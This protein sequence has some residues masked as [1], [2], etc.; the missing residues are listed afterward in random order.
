VTQQIN[1]WPMYVFQAG[2]ALVSPDGGSPEIDAPPFKQALAFTSDLVL[3]HR[4]AP[5]PVGSAD[6]LRPEPLFARG[7]VAMLEVS[8]MALDHLVPLPFRWSLLP[9]PRQAQSVTLLL[10]VGIAIN[11]ATPHAAACRALV[12]Y[13]LSPPVQ[14]FFGMDGFCIPAIAP[15]LHGRDRNGTAK[16]MLRSLL[17]DAHV[18]TA[19][20]V[21]AF[22]SISD[23]LGMTLAGAIAL[24][25]AIEHMHRAATAALAALAEGTAG[26]EGRQAA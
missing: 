1:R 22:D 4:V 18:L 3:R 21:V 14:E 17:P 15:P 25:D 26:T 13:L 2:G 11:R 10:P 6:R 19:A 5:H 23:L 8:G 9:P 24:P 16:A 20:E 12:D 7:D